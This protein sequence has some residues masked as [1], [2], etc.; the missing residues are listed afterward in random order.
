MFESKS[1]G[2]SSDSLKQTFFMVKTIGNRSNSFV[3][4]SVI[5]SYTINFMQSN[6]HPGSSMKE[7]KCKKC[8]IFFTWSLCLI[9]LSLKFRTFLHQGLWSLIPNDKSA[10]S[11]ISTH[12]IERLKSYFRFFFSTFRID[13]RLPISK[14]AFLRKSSCDN[15]AVFEWCAVKQGQAREDGRISCHHSVI[16]FDREG[17]HFKLE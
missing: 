11:A 10:T 2:G 9:I 17:Q 1:G 8:F 15:S 13:I 16:S 12:V 3:V 4:V 6:S 7:K 14:K 5:D